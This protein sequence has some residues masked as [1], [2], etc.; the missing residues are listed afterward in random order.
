MIFFPTVHE[1]PTPTALLPP[2]PLQLRP[3][4]P[5]ERSAAGARPASPPVT[6]WH[7][8]QITRNNFF[9]RKDKDKIWGRGSPEPKPLPPPSLAPVDTDLG[10]GGRRGGSRAR[11]GGGGRGSSGRRGSNGQAGFLRGDGGGGRVL[12]RV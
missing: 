4:L 5:G 10:G 1:D 6:P 2:V 9:L 7:K 3:P 8:S 12:V 11:P